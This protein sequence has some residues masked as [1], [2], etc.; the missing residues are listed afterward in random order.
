[1]L[2]ALGPND[3]R[4]RVKTVRVVGKRVGGEVVK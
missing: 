3:R 1:M 4:R 2:H